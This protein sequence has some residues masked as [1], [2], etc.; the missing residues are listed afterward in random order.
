MRSY[1]SEA[2][3][4]GRNFTGTAP[5]DAHH[6]RQQKQL[7]QHPQENIVHGEQG[8]DHRVDEN[9]REAVRALAERHTGGEPVAYLIGEWEFYGLT[10]E[11]TPDGRRRRGQ[12]VQNI[13]LYP[14][15]Q[16]APPDVPAAD[17][18]GLRWRSLPRC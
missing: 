4:P 8:K 2:A 6:K 7:D 16:S 5:C 14:V 13:R 1:A 10:L 18:Q 12:G 17:L 11:V 3:R 15:R 9:C